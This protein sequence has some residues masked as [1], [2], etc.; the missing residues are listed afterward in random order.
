MCVD[1][2]SYDLAECTCVL[3]ILG[4]RF[5]ETFMNSCHLKIE[6]VLF[7]FPSVCTFIY[8]YHL[9]IVARTFSTMLSKSSENGHICFLPNLRGILVLGGFLV[10]VFLLILLT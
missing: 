7:I 8:L 4:G 1:L 2:L 3:K 6:K 10:Y 9:N 5:L